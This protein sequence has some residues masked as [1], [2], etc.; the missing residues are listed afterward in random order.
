MKLTITS[1]LRLPELA[2]PPALTLNSVA[3]STSTSRTI[4]G[5]SEPFANIEVTVHSTPQTK[6]TVADASGNWSLLFEGLESGSHTV[7]VISTDAGGNI[8]E[9]L[10]SFMVLAASVTTGPLTSPPVLAVTPTA[11]PFTQGFVGYNPSEVASPEEDILAVSD[12]SAADD[13]AIL[14]AQ[15]DGTGTPLEDTDV[16]GLMD[17]KIVRY[18]VVLVADYPCRIGCSMASYRRRYPTKSHSGIKFKL[19]KAKA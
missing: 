14:S 19:E 10:S 15:D 8:S 18:C 13:S 1:L 5:T 17:E 11:Q 3:S 2:V 16:L 6:S 7:R 9:Q 4:S 12:S